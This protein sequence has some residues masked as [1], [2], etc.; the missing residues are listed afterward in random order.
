MKNRKNFLILA[1][2]TLVLVLGVGYAVVSSVTLTIT[3][4]GASKTEDLKVVYD[5]VNSGTTNGD[6]NKVTAISSPDDS[7][8]ATFTLTDMVL[9]TPAELEFEIQNKE[10]DVNATLS[11]PSVTQNTKSNFFGV[12]FAYKAGAR[13]ASGNFSDWTSGTKTLAAGEKATIKVIV[14][15]TNTPIQESDSSTSISVSINAAPAAQ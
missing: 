8:A 1:I 11:L 5:G 4:T 2:V 10:T 6:V 14:S 7:I 13:S 12:T 9:S 3:G 15:L